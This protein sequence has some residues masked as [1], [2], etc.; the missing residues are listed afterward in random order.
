MKKFAVVLFGIAVV[1][2]MAAEKDYTGWAR[3]MTDSKSINHYWVMISSPWNWQTKVLKV[4][5]PPNDIKAAAVEYEI[6]EEPYDGATKTTIK[7][8]N[9]NW[10]NWQITVNGTV[11]LDQSAGPYIGKGIHRV[12]FPAK[13]LKEGE[14]TIS[15]GWKMVPKEERATKKWGYVYLAGD[16]TDANKEVSGSPKSLARAKKYPESIRIRLLLKF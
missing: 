6:N 10:H 14:N 9:Y 7:A 15:M 11:I 4:D 1:C 3:V 16:L 5:V 13:L 2:I 12:E 8:Q